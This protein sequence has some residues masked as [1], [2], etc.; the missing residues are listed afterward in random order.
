MII[1]TIINGIICVIWFVEMTYAQFFM[2]KDVSA[3]L[4]YSYRL[5]SLKKS[6]NN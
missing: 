6:K 4:P 3:R 5:V 2:L 1:I